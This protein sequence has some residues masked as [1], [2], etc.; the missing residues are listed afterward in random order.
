MQ[1]APPHTWYGQTVG[2]SRI[3]DDNPDTV[4]RF[5]AVNKTSTYVIKGKFEDY[6]PADP[7]TRP[8]DTSF[9]LLTGLSGNTADVLTKDELIV[10]DDGTFEIYVSGAPRPPDYEAT[11]SN[12]RPTPP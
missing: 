11:T 5:M 4:Y 7:T 10:N 6:D 12:L 2:G 9:S 3:L 8:A 1:V